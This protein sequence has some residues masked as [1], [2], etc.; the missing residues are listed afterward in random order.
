MPTS[1]FHI[2]VH[3]YR[4]E[5]TTKDKK[6]Y[7]ERST[8]LASREMTI[9]RI[10]RLHLTSVRT[11]IIKETNHQE[12]LEKLQEKK[13]LHTAAGGYKLVQVLWKSAWRIKLEQSDH[14]GY[15]VYLQRRNPRESKPTHQRYLH[16][17]VH[18]GTAHRAKTCNVDAYHE[19]KGVG[20][21]WLSSYECLLGSSPTIHMATHNHL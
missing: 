14:S 12:M 20:E 17:H 2:H 15:A 6:M 21:R 9:R 10:L 19:G 11:S 7:G 4:F 8:S 5:K 16:V 18:C 3:L 1:G 13:L